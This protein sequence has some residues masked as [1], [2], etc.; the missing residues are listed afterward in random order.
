MQYVLYN[1][2][3]PLLDADKLVFEHEFPQF[4]VQKEL[5]NE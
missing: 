2:F 4:N 1:V 3:W 5:L